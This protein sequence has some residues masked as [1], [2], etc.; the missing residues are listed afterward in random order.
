MP[1]YTSSVT[2]VTTA[3]EARTVM[4]QM[5]DQLTDQV[6]ALRAQHAEIEASVALNPEVADAM[7][8][9]VEAS[10]KHAQA[11][12]EVADTLLASHAADWD[13]IERGDVK[14]EAWDVS[15]NRA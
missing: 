11:Y 3:S 5:P 8:T 1:D 2:G 12:S 6:Q 14:D 7:T 13:K 4:T 9:Y 15:R 10:D